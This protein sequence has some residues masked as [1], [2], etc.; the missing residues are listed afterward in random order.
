MPLQ[1]PAPVVLEGNYTTWTYQW[2]KNQNTD[3]GVSSAAELN[4]IISYV[5]QDKLLVMF[6]D[7]AQVAFVVLS[8]GVLDTFV[9]P[10]IS[11]GN[12]AGIYNYTPTSFQRRYWAGAIND[13]TNAVLKIFK[14]GSLIQSIDLTALLGWIKTIPVGVAIS[15]DGK[16][17]A[18]QNYTTHN[19]ALLVGS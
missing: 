5:S 2:T 12:Y 8:T 19:I 3:W 4:K 1:I 18:C 17:I 16:Y 9:N 7:F 13:G 11:W 6:G 14:D 15:E 10:T